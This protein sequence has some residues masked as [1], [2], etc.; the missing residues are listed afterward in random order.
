MDTY[1]LTDQ[2]VIIPVHNICDRFMV[3]PDIGTTVLQSQNQRVFPKLPLSE[4]IE[5]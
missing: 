5:R 3:D 2:I 4:P 1:S